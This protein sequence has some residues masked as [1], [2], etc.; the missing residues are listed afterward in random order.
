MRV[1]AGSASCGKVRPPFSAR[2]RTGGK[3]HGRS[4]DI[5]ALAGSRR[6]VLWTFPRRQDQVRNVFYMVPLRR[7]SVANVPCNLRLWREGVT[8][9]PCTS[10]P[11]REITGAFPRRL[12]GFLGE[13]LNLIGGFAKPACLL[14]FSSTQRNRR[15][16]AVSAFIRLSPFVCPP[17][18]IDGA[19]EIQSIRWG[20]LMA[21][22]D[23]IGQS[24]VRSRA[25]DRNIP[26]FRFA[27]R[28]L[29]GARP[30]ASGGRL[31]RA[32]KRSKPTKN[33]LVTSDWSF[34]LVM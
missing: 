27:P 23:L 6:H 2:S 31:R 34:R 18:G 12:R 9:V 28:W 33:L 24:G 11:T 10:P 25:P 20:G 4:R 16:L 21:M 8:G 3:R 29:K 32:Q 14:P 5:P 30:P 13:H 1:A 17:R 15:R 19:R 7:E 26:L 22:Q